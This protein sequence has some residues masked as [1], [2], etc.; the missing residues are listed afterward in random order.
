M[1]ETHQGVSN[2]HDRSVDVAGLARSWRRRAEDQARRRAKLAARAR[3]EV[4]ELAHILVTRYG[5]RRVL[6]F[7]SLV[8]PGTFRETSDIDLA[9]EGIPPE[10]FVKASAELA[11]MSFFPVDLVPLEAC[12]PALRHVIAAYGVELHPQRPKD[13]EKGTRP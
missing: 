6:L 11:R 9:A 7:G 4:Q 8:G 13:E 5:A 10:M 12:A 3:A 1:E 2:V